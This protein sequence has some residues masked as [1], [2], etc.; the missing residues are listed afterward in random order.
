M[1]FLTS[2]SSH[3]FLLGVKTNSDVTMFSTHFKSD[4]LSCSLIGDQEYTV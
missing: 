3:H 4:V 1:R 2:I